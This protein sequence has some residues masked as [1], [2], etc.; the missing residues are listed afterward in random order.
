[1]ELDS[2]S[3]GQDFTG[4]ISYLSRVFKDL[5]AGKDCLVTGEK[6]LIRTPPNFAGDYRSPII[7]ESQLSVRLCDR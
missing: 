2:R 1:M 3:S 5:G 6:N 4:K 7:P